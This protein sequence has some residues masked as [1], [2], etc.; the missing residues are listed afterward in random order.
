MSD[1]TCCYLC[2]RYW[3]AM[4]PC[5]HVAAVQVTVGI[6]CPVLYHRPM[7]LAFTRHFEATNS[8]RS[9]IIQHTMHPLRT[10]EEVSHTY[11]E[12]NEYREIGVMYWD[13]E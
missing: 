4:Q 6:Y 2:M 3:H 8:I 12:W 7:L 10:P 5:D 13:F 9:H 1:T 11:H